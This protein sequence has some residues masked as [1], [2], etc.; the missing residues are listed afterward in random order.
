MTN[1]E[2]AVIAQ[3]I[4]E[5]PSGWKYDSIINELEKGNENDYIYIADFYNHLDSR[6]VAR[7]MEHSVTVLNSIF[8]EK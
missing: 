1:S 6:E 5:Y 3:Y 2:I 8:G 4:D 7:L